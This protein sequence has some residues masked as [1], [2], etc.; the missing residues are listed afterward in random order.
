MKVLWTE[1]AVQDLIEI[2]NYIARNNPERAVAFIEFLIETAERIV[3]NPGAGRI[4]PELMNP[5]IREMIAKKYRIVYRVEQDLIQI[6]TVFEG[7]RL[8]RENEI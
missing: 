7:H 5:A 3:E 6:L 4:V 8:L 2:E 1:R